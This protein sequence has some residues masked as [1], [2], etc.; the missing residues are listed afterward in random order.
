[1]LTD[2]IMGA[3]TFKKGIY[4]QTANDST[5]TQ[6]AWLIVIIVAFLS[7]LGALAGNIQHSFFGWL[8]GAI[9]TSAVMVGAFWLSAYVLVLL[10]KAL[11]NS[12]VQFDQVVRALGLAYIW[13]VV[14]FL[15]IVNVI[16]FLGCLTAPIQLLAGLVA[17]AANLIAIKD[18]TSLDWV[19]T[20]VVVVVAFIITAILVAIVGL[21]LGI[22]GLLA[23]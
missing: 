15:G 1:M 22:V 12:N 2:R 8:I 5:F 16:P 23:R 7:Q 20:I 4:Q 3:L 14:G 21:F 6:N 18:S 19:G 10:A 17:I 11:F 9:I 13:R